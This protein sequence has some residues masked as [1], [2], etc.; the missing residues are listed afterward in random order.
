MPL[1]LQAQGSLVSG[2]RLAQRC[3]PG[4]AWTRIRKGVTVV[5]QPPGGGKRLV[6]SGVPRREPDP[7]IR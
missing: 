6:R 3:F 1:P 7:F 2:L 4:A 5:G